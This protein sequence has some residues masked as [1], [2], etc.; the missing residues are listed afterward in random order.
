VNSNLFHAEV[1]AETEAEH[2]VALEDD[3]ISSVLKEDGK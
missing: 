1:R 3:E 2:M